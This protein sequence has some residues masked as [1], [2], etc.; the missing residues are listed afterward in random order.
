MSTYSNRLQ[1]ALQKPIIMCCSGFPPEIV[2]HDAYISGRSE[3]NIKCI[4]LHN[5]LRWRNRTTQY[6]CRFLLLRHWL[7]VALRAIFLSFIVVEHIRLF[8]GALQLVCT[9]CRASRHTNTRWMALW[10][11][12]MDLWSFLM[13]HLL[14]TFIRHWCNFLRQCE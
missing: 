11:T 2:M 9:F 5:D 14:I 10:G 3:N 6:N 7:K 1:P 4:V 8:H 13:Q 12:V